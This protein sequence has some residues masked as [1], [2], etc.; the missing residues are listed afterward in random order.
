MF[1]LIITV[2]SIALISLIALATLYFGG[3]SFNEGS[4]KAAAA[5]VVNQASQISGANTLH[6]LDEQAYAADTAALVTGDYLA[7]T[8]NPGKISADSYVLGGATDST[9]SLTGVNVALCEAVNTQAGVTVDLTAIS[10]DTTP[11]NG[12]PDELEDVQF[13]CV[14][15][16]VT[17]GSEAYKFIFK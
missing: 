1:S 8:P 13:G 6:Y 12:I 7:S 11:S 14:A 10:V 5:T 9:I 2:I 4:A 17:A 3:D 15:T 16:N